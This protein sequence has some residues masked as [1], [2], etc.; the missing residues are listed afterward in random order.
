MATLKLYTKPTGNGN[1][2]RIWAKI[3]EANHV[4]KLEVEHYNRPEWAD[5]FP[6]EIQVTPA[7]FA[8]WTKLSEDRGGR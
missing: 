3:N 8:R 5:S 7:E 4:E 1:S 6:I 2:R